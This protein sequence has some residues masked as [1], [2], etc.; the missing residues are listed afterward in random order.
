MAYFQAIIRPMH[1]FSTYEKTIQL[2]INF[3]SVST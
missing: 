1:L 2:L 3:P